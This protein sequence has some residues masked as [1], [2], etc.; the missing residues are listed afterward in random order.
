M[1][2]LI[3]KIILLIIII[4]F[5]QLILFILKTKH[6]VNYIVVNNKE[7][8]KINE[9]YKNNNYLFDIEYKNKNIT[10]SYDNKFY[11]AKK[12]IKD[13]LV[14]EKDD[15][16]CIYPVL[17][18]NQNYNIICSKD[19]LMYH[20]DYFKSELTPF[21]SYLTEQG[22]IN[23]A[24]FYN[25]SKI[26]MGNLTFYHENINKNTYIYIWKYK[27]FYTLNSKKQQT[28][29]IL[30]NDT[31]VNTLGIKVGKYYVLPNYDEKYN[32]SSFYIIN[33]TN[34]RVKTLK[35]DK[36]ITNDYYNNGVIDN[37]LYLFDVDN[38]IQ[39]KLNPKK[40]KIEKISN[41]EA[42]F[43]DN[44]KFIKRNLYDFKENKL[45]F[46]EKQEDVSFDYKKLFVNDNHYYYLEKNNNMI[47]YNKF[48][49]NKMILFNIKDISNIKLV[50]NY[51]YFISEDTLYS[52][53]IDEGIKMLIKYSEFYYNPT[54]RYEIYTK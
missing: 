32:F 12:V 37:K 39:Y 41:T 14:Y 45:I 8:I 2:D 53:N 18:N 38:L 36:K 42:L 11:K 15:L 23:S 20:Y 52:F 22:Y 27:G 4:L 9:T 1:K 47:Y 44:D 54:N 46:N 26:N 5:L 13:I 35:L 48:I 10:F 3:K 29:D 50:N 19:D 31:Y 25:N 24:W 40:N 51:L 28:L 6:N 49:D 17:K 30:K 33:M 21:T 34:N 43:Y 7:K 16:V